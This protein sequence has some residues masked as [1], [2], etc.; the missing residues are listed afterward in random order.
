M[1]IVTQVMVGSIPILSFVHLYCHL[2]S[3]FLPIRNKYGCD[4][5]Q[6]LL[7]CFM[8]PTVNPNVTIFSILTCHSE[9]QFS[10]SKNVIWLLRQSLS[11][12]SASIHQVRLVSPHFPLVFISRFLLHKLIQTVVTPLTFNR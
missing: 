11:T 3:S 7:S 2:A 8:N 1:F 6:K 10:V 9:L 5:N 12:S 4:L